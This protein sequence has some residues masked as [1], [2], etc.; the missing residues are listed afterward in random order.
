MNAQFIKTPGGEELVVLGR[1]DYEALLAA[2]AEADE[3]AADVA[4]YDAAKAELEAGN[5][6]L[7][8]V[9]ISAAIHK[10]KNRIRAIRD[11]AGMTQSDVADRAGISQ[12]Y[13]SAIEA[14]SRQLS[15]E[16]AGKLAG[17]LGVPVVWIDP[18]PTR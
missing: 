12:S 16:L 1:A 17:A 14:G 7:L 6:A 9:A 10:G 4:V 11:F 13:L 8:P 2:A 3:D 18:R 15:I 5:D